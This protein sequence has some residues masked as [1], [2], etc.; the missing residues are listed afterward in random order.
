MPEEIPVDYVR[1]LWQHV[2]L[3]AWSDA[4]EEDSSQSP[5]H[6]E[7][8]RLAAVQWLTIYSRDLH[9]VCEN[10]GV[11]YKEVMKKAKENF[12]GEA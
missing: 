5:G 3:I 6:R 2:L 8:S 4:N 12:S 1:R 11:D 10:A 7:R 9:E